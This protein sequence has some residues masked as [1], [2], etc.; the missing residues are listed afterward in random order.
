MADVKLTP[1]Q[2]GDDMGFYK[3]VADM[4][5]AARQYARWQLDSTITVTYSSFAVVI[6]HK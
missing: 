6:L 1:I 5:V 3:Q 2:N 4:L